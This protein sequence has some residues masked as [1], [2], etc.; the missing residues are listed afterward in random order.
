MS[1]RRRRRSLRKR[2]RRSR[3]RGRSRG[4]NKSGRRSRGSLKKRPGEEIDRIR[5]PINHST[6]V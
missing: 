1:W 6:V 4:K 2:F 3:D 5:A